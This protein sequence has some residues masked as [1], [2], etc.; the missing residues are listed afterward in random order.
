MTKTRLACIALLSFVVGLGATSGIPGLTG[1][2]IARAAEGIPTFQVDAEWPKLPNNWIMGDPASVTVDS[3]D[4]IWVIQRPRTL[5]VE[6]REHV[7]PAVLEFDAS[8]KFVRAWGGPSDAYDWPDNEHLIYVDYKDRVWIAGNNP[9]AQVKATPRSDDMLLE[10]TPEGKFVR[11]FGHRDSSKGNTDT[12]NLNGPAEMVVYQNTNEMFIADGYGN[13]RVIVLD[14]DTLAFKRMWGAFGNVPMKLTPAP[15]RTMEGPGPQ[16]FGTVH[17]I[18]ISND[19]RVYIGDRG[20]SR[21]QVFTLDGKYITQGFVAR[22]SK[23]S[24]TTGGLAFSPDPQQRFIYSADQG[25]HHVHIVV[26]ETF[27][28]V[29]Y[30]GEEGKAAG[31]FHAPH[32]LATD[33]KGNIYTVEVQGGSRVQRFLFMGMKPKV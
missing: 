19:G 2:Q 11:Q 17:S 24:S 21:I 6:Q 15:A 22:A 5:P 30:F 23:S 26:R 28:E 29:G 14:A 8:G 1:V 32:H 27:E 12:S 20:N 3:H 7:A 16:Q 33:S 25:N 18:K 10:F 13:Q 4:N 9:S 31:N